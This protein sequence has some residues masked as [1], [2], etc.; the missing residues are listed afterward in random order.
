MYFLTIVRARVCTLLAF[1]LL[2]GIKGTSALSHASCFH[3]QTSRFP[4][5][6]LKLQSARR[7]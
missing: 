7:A 4:L 3:S 2:L 6:Y 5:G 1:L